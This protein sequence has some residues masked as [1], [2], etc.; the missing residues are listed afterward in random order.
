M[1]SPRTSDA[2]RVAVVAALSFVLGLVGWNLPNGGRVSLASVPILLLALQD[3]WRAGTTAGAVAGFLHFF[4]EY[5]AG[6]PVS[7]VLDYPVASACLG[8][9][10]LFRLPPTLV[11]RSDLAILRGA[12]GVGV[13][14]LVK[15]SVHVV[16]G[17]VFWS[18]GL[19][20]S[21]AWMLSLHYNAC[22]M[23]PQL[24]IDLALV[25]PLA[26]RVS[27]VG[28]RHASS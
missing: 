23:G 8:V 14:L 25:P 15:Y 9:A 5:V 16:S 24:L 28:R 21:A 22:Y 13:A 20:G 10:G 11:V 1:R 12:I 4:Q 18:Q 7:L 2:A 19:C 26:L 3:G 27:A 6:H 17:I